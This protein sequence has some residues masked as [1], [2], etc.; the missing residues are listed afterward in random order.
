MSGGDECWREL[1][2]GR[3]GSAKGMEKMGSR[4]G[5]RYIKVVDIMHCSARR[6]RHKLRL[7]KVSVFMRAVDVEI[8]SRVIGLRSSESIC[9][10]AWA[11]WLTML[12]IDRTAIRSRQR[13]S[14]KEIFKF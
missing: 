4:D 12:E 7:L 10:T 1:D 5:M 9:I 14:F 2:R 6:A 13:V 3:G 8:N 11:A